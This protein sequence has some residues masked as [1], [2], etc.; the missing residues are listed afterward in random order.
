MS[1]II[2]IIIIIIVIIIV[3][4]II[5]M[6]LRQLWSR[7]GWL[8]WISL[9]VSSAAS[10]HQRG[11]ESGGDQWSWQWAKSWLKWWWGWCDEDN[12][13]MYP[14]G[15]LPRHRWLDRLSQEATRLAAGFDRDHNHQQSCW[16][17]M[18]L[19]GDVYLT[20]VLFK[21]DSKSTENVNENSVIRILFTILFYF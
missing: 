7:A 5:I 20:L 21:I 1:L 12:D 6:M 8:A 2:I 3:I 11:R 14:S 10:S 13:A 9:S 17:L 16:W 19:K 15:H 4:I 18:V